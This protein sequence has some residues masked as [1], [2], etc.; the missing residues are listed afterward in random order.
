M[1]ALHAFGAEMLKLSRGLEGMVGSPGNQTPSRSTPQH[2]HQHQQQ[3]QQQQ[4]QL[5]QLQQ[6]GPSPR[7]C[8]FRNGYAESRYVFANRKSFCKLVLYPIYPLDVL[9]FVIMCHL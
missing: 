5:L 8:S 9:S 2:Q 4:Q 1:S 3:Q 7:R 6:H